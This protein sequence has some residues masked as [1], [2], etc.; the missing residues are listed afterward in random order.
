[1][2]NLNS[3]TLEEITKDLKEQDIINMISEALTEYD[4]TK[5][6]ISIEDLISS[7]GLRKEDLL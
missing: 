6:S 2:V 5:E 4:L 7:Y 3:K 1:M